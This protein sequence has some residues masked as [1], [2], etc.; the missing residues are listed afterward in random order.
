[1]TWGGPQYK[2]AILSQW[3]S[4]YTDKTAS[5][6]R[7]IFTM[8]ITILP[9]RNF[10]LGSLPRLGIRSLNG[11]RLTILRVWWLNGARPFTNPC[12]TKVKDSALQTTTR[13][14]SLHDHDQ[15]KTDFIGFWLEYLYCYMT[16]KSCY[17]DIQLT[18]DRIG[19]INRPIIGSSHLFHWL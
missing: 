4:H 5:R 12:P 3:D 14:W 7:L 2:N 6:D 18:N 1:M 10:G 19:I 13:E 15:I 16:C 11:F 17:F 9:W 8:G